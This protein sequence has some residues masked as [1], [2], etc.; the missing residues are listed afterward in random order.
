MSVSDRVEVNARLLMTASSE[1]TELRQRVRAVVAAQGDDVFFQAVQQGNSRHALWQQLGAEG[2]LGR[3]LPA[4]LGGGG[5]GLLELSVVLEECA[6]AGIPLTPGIFSSAVAALILR[7]HGSTEQ[8]QRWLPGIAAGR[9]LLSFAMTE[10]EGGLNPARMATLATR[11]GDGDWLLNGTKSYVTAIDQSDAVLVVASDGETQGLSM[12]LVDSRDAGL[13]WVPFGTEVNVPER[14]FVVHLRNVRVPDTALVGQVGR[15]LKAAFAGMNAERIL[16]SAICTGIGQYALDK[17]VVRAS[18]RTVWST[19]I[20]AHQALAHPL[21]RAHVALDSARLVARR[22]LDLYDAG[23][24][25]GA[26]AN[27]AKLTG[28]AA[29]LQALDAAIQVFGGDGVKSDAGLAHYWFLLRSYQLGPVPDEMAL[30]FIAEHV[31][32]LPRSY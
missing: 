17:A 28:A 25:P 19:P 7:A 20:G 6:R 18:E 23:A 24:D 29:G 27:M 14:S 9:S 22:A 5:H 13:E 32:G 1:E 12:F 10:A 8:Q 26:E 21:A 2:L 15:G 30:N 16:A 4:E 3:H 11:A 31:L